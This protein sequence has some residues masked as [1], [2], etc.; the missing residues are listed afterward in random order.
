VVKKGSC[1]SVWT[2]RAHGYVALP[3]SRLD[4]ADQA[5]D[6]DDRLAPDELDPNRRP[7]F[8]P[9]QRRAVA[10]DD[11]LAIHAV[12]A[13][14]LLVD[15]PQG[16]HGV[17]QRWR[18]RE[19]LHQGVVRGD[20]PDEA[21]G[22]DH[23][24]RGVGLDPGDGRGLALRPVPVHDTVEDGFARGAGW[25]QPDRALGE[26]PRKGD[27]VVRRRQQVLHPG[28]LLQQAQPGGAARS[29]QPAPARLL[30]Q[31]DL[32]ALDRRW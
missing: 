2:I 4:L 6:R 9:D 7:W 14:A 25:Q 22:G 18:T 26:G 21:A 5:H 8:F 28:Q 23:F 20:A 17:R 11:H 29:A 19:S 10:E 31:V 30:L 24:N 27:P 16:S 1:S 15:Q 13:D 3:N 32:L 12:H